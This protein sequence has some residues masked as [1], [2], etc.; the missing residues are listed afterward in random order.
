MLVRFSRPLRWSVASSSCQLSSRTVSSRTGIFTEDDPR[1]APRKAKRLTRLG[2]LA[3]DH[4]ESLR[5]RQDGIPDKGELLMMQANRRIRA[6]TEAGAFDNLAGAGKPLPK[7]Y[8]VDTASP[9]GLAHHILKNSGHA[10][11]W[12][13]LGKKIEKD[14]DA[15]RMRLSIARAAAA[16]G[17]RGAAAVG[18]R[19]EA[20]K[21]E[22][23]EAIAQV[24]GNIRR[25]NLSAPSQIT[26]RPQMTLEIELGKLET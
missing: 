7:G 19:W 17:A 20:A 12:I 8:A 18:P 10:P 6:A 14:A 24:N 4:E 22:A 2:M 3:D 5:T 9:E 11:P 15:L 25:F 16:S 21:T 1:A 26:H 23:A 13:E